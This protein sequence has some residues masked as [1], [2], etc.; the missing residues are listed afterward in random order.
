MEYANKR[1]LTIL[2]VDT[3][4]LSVTIRSC[5][6]GNQFFLYFYVL[7]HVISGTLH[8]ILSTS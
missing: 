1:Y 2:D 4:R 6:L 5:R 8:I 3:K 7:D